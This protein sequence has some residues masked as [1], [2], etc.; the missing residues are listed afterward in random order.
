MHTFPHIMH[1]WIRPV[2]SILE[3]MFDEFNE[4]VNIHAYVAPTL[5]NNFVIRQFSIV[6]D[7]E[8]EAVEV[9]QRLHV[10]N[11]YWLK[12]KLYPDQFVFNLQSVA[13]LTIE[14]LIYLCKV[15][16]VRDFARIAAVLLA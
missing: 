9:F 11:P 16:G 3:I 6:C 2:D 8:E 4:S 15:I 7:E 14:Q 10:L 12:T 13:T 5:E 1:E